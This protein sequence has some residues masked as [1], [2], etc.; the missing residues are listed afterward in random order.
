MIFRL[1]CVT[2]SLLYAKHM[3]AAVTQNPRSKVTV[4]GGKV[5]LSCHQTFNHDNMYWYRQD[6]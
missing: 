4:T 3:E 2:L 6:L 5:E 1:F